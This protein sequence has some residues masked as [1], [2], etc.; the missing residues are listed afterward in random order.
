M[1]SLVLL[2]LL[3]LWVVPP[4]VATHQS[5]VTVDPADVNVPGRR[6]VVQPK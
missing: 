4:A 5:I 3:Y 6:V 2:L 1:N